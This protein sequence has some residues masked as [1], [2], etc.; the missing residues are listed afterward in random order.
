[1]HRILYASAA[2]HHTMHGLGEHWG[3]GG[4]ATWMPSLRMHMHARHIL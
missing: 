2:V 4:S 3:D 1:M